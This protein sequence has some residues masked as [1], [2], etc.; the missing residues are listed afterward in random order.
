[1]K[2]FTNV[3]SVLFPCEN[4][5]P[6][7]FPLGTSWAKNFLPNMKSCCR[8][9]RIKTFMSPGGSLG[10]PGIEIRA[11]N[12]PN[13]PMG[14]PF[15][16]WILTPGVGVKWFNFPPRLTKKSFDMTTGH[17]VVWPVSYNPGYPTN[18]GFF[19]PL[20]VRVIGR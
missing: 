1:M 11:R 20:A 2:L 9:S 7:D 8:S 4:L 19:L 15:A 5:M 13:G 10:N 16:P 6:K 3:H 18:K 12:S 14:E 17:C